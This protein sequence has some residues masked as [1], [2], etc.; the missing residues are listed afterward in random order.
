[1]KI[2]SQVLT[3]ITRDCEDNE[4]SVELKYYG[5]ENIRDYQTIPLFQLTRNHY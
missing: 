1:M 3:L 2:T 4:T 5:N